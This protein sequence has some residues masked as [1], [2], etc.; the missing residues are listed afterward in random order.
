MKELGKI[1]LANYK[2]YLNTSELGKF[3]LFN[4]YPSIL[5]E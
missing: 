3:K 4:V 2:F 1:F 5:N